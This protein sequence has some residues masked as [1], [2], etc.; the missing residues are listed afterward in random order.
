M[1][2]LYSVFFK[3][4]EKNSNIEY[5]FS[6]KFIINGIQYTCNIGSINLKDIGL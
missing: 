2:S 4:F 1:D 5:I 6:K 3:Y